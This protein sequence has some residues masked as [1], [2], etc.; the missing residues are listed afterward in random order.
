MP[1]TSTPSN[2][3]PHC[4]QR[5]RRT[6]RL[7]ADIARNDALGLRRYRCVEAACGWQ[8]LLAQGHRRQRCAAV[9]VPASTAAP[10]AVA[11]PRSWRQ[12]L[13]LLVGAAAAVTVPIVL[14][15]MMGLGHWFERQSLHGLP[16]GDSHDG[17]PLPA[18]HALQA[19][20]PAEDA[21][22]ADQASGEPALALREGCAWGQPGRNPYKGST[23]QALRLARLPPEVVRQVAQM[24]RARDVTDRLEIRTGAIRAVHSQR[25]YNP[26]SFAMTFGRTLCIDARVNFAPGHVERADLYEARDASGRLHAVMVP[27]VCGNVS[28]LGARG[29]RVAKPQLTAALVAQGGPAPWLADVSGGQGAHTRIGWLADLR[30]LLGMAPDDEGWARAPRQAVALGQA[31]LQ[32]VPE[33]GSLACVLAALAALAAVARARRR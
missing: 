29:Q 14:V 2:P 33:P 18:R 15:L 19:W 17:R 22:L 13:W 9:A 30:H 27:D 5:L 7:N 24:R 8:G 23:E 32:E 6:R 31:G 16:Q 28:V 11:T 26:R 21:A 25:E 20:L 3:C 12:L 1:L 10:V 4:G